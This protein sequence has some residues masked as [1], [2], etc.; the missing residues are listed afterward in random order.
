MFRKYLLISTLVCGLMSVSIGQPIDHDELKKMDLEQRRALHS[1]LNQGAPGLG[2]KP[3]PVFGG[4][5]YHKHNMDQD[6]ST[7]NQGALGH[8]VTP[9]GFVEV[10]P[11]GLGAPGL[12]VTP[13]PNPIVVGGIISNK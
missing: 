4:V 6:L 12:G 11:V 1:I 2:V 7:T 10:K 8:E 13:R 3:S 5:M 9:D